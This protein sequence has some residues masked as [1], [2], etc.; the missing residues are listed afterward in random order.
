MENGNRQT[1]YY[2][3]ENNIKGYLDVAKIWLTYFICDFPIGILVTCVTVVKCDA[4]KRNDK[5]SRTR[6]R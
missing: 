2:S 3:I 6:E 5:N 1:H 4:I